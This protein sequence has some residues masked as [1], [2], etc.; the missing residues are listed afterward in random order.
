M[1]IVLG[2]AGAG[3]STL[4]AGLEQKLG[5]RRLSIGDLLRA[6]MHG[7]EARRMLE[8]ELIDDEKW[9]PLLEKELQSLR[10][11]EFILDGSP[12]TLK[13][14]QWLVDKIEKYGLELSVII[15]L[16]ASRNV[17]KR[18]LLARGRPDDHEKAIAERFA[19]YEAKIMPILSFLDKKGYK[20]VDIDGEQSKQ[21]VEEEAQRAVRATQT[22]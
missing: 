1:I 12:R 10:G 19:E 8:G 14:A 17:V 2:L 3:K 18:R 16:T 20:V 13:Q 21:A 5:C 15:H 7:E 9:L 6:N 11:S 22:S 4:A